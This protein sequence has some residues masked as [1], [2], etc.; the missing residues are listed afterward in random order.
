MFTYFNDPSPLVT[1]PLPPPPILSQRHGKMLPL[2]HP[3]VKYYPS[4]IRKRCKHCVRPYLG[5]E[6]TASNSFGQGPSQNH[7]LKLIRRQT[8]CKHKCYAYGLLWPP[9]GYTWHDT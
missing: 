8:L 2:R 3:M 7:M 4:S 6:G 5:P 1:S 9:T